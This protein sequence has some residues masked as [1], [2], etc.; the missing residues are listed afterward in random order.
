MSRYMQDEGYSFI[1]AS[2]GA[3]ALEKV[4]SEMPDL[5]LLDVNMPIKDGFAVLAE[6]REDP[7]IGHIPVIIFTAARLNPMDMQEGLSSVPM[8]TSS[9][10]LTGANCLRA[11]VRNCV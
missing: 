11:S 7:A 5:V 4:R 3:E 1:T 8:I 2:N 10:L 6:I 9:S